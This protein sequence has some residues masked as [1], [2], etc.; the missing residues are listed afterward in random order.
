MR[1]EGGAKKEIKERSQEK[2]KFYLR[3]K[4]KGGGKWYED[5]KQV[6]QLNVKRRQEK[7]EQLQIS[8]DVKKRE[9][10]RRLSKLNERKETRIE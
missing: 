6:T 10:E 3:S 8:I 9:R 5:K 4:G 1:C 2:Q 7:R